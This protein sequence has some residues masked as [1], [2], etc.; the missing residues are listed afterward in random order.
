MF[1]RCDSLNIFSATLYSLPK[2]V[3]MTIF[4]LSI[5]SLSLFHQPRCASCNYFPCQ[6]WIISLSCILTHLSS[7]SLVTSTPCLY[8]LGVW[9]WLSS[10]LPSSNL[11][12]II[13]RSSL[14]PLSLSPT[15]APSLAHNHLSPQSIYSLWPESPHHISD[16]T[17]PFPHVSWYMSSHLTW[18][19]VL[20]LSY[21]AHHLW[22]DPL[23]QV[24]ELFS[25]LC[26]PRDESLYDAP[27]NIFAGSARIISWAC[28]W[29][30]PSIVSVST[31]LP[32]TT[33]SSLLQPACVKPLISL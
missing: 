13:R 30:Q 4:Q 11:C 25:L 15:L 5:M 21:R 29:A 31:S 14:K 24:H 2:S 6:A 8:C 23:S 27:I 3:L 7:P 18:F 33:R 26:V 19:L 32:T 10:I 16:T 22:A 20:S 28:L 9:L 12:N 1:K 17:Q